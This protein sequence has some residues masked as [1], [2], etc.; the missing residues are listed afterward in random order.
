MKNIAIKFNL[1]VSVLKEGKSFVAYTP[2]L[3]LST[4]GKTLE[5]AQKNFVDKQINFLSCDL[6]SKEVEKLFK[7]HNFKLEHL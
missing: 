2:A 4:A 3:D 7:S 5:D 6:F 1:P